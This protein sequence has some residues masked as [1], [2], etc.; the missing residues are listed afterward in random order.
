MGTDVLQFTLFVRDF[1]LF[2]LSEYI[3]EYSY[4]NYYSFILD[5]LINLILTKKYDPSTPILL[6]FGYLKH[7]IYSKR[8]KDRAS[9]YK[10]DHSLY[11]TEPYRYRKVIN[12]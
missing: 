10:F 12:Y 6:T 9:V 3:E 1:F 8:P 2:V 7:I 11:C 5:P 4:L